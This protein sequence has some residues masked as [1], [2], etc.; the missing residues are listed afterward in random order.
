MAD[1]ADAHRAVFTAYTSSSIVDKLRRSDR[2]GVSSP[3]VDPWQ[4]AADLIRAM[5]AQNS[6]EMLDN[7]AFYEPERVEKVR[8]AWANE[9]R[10]DPSQSGYAKFMGVAVAQGLL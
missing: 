6:D 9:G 7:L 2:A 1:T 5:Y 4:E 3:T 10:S 8:R